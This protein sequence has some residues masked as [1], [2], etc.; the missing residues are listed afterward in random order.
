MVRAFG[1]RWGTRT[2]W[3][4]WLNV[5]IWVPSVYLMF[6]AVLSA[7]F[8]PDLGF[9]PQVGIALVLVAANWV[10][11]LVA[12][13]TGKWV[14]NLGAILTVLVIAVLGVGGAMQLADGTGSA[15]TFAWSTD[16]MI[17]SGATMALAISII[18]YN[19]LGFELM[20]SASNEM[21]DARRDVP[22]SI[23]VAGL[24][25]GAFYLIATVGMQVILPADQISETSGLMD[26]LTTA[27]GDGP[28]VTVLGVGILYAFFAAL[29]PWTIGAN[30]SAAEASDRGDLPPVF[31]RMSPTRGTPV[32]AANLTAAVSAGFTVAYGV[33]FS[34][35][36]GG[37]DELFW[38]LFAFSSVIF[39]FPYMVMAAAFLRLRLTDADAVRPYRVPGGAAGAWLSTVL[40]VALL[41]AATVFFVWDPYGEFDPRTFWLIMAGLLATFVVQEIFVHL[42]P[43]WK[44]RAA[45]HPE[46][47]AEVTLDGFA[48]EDASSL[49]AAPR[50]PQDPMAPPTA[51]P[52]TDRARHDSTR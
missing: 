15:T 6:S 45:E 3:W 38:S 48:P 25:I 28:L 10:V 17:P 33:L 41:A 12:L 22:R 26:A 18:I 11:N 34:L 42:A 9:W 30:R 21:H 1:S 46:L 52:P 7:M 13:E 8:F 39:L 40:V 36:D 29:I 35:T 5:A 32:G 19:F 2:S 50:A 4:Y 24:L 31:G 27:L 43:G 14:S 49:A 51:A 23:V 20:S 44:R 37:I 47:L 16:S